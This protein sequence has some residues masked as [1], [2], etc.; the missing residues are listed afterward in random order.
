MEYILGFVLKYLL[1]ALKDWGVGLFK[2]KNKFDSIDKTVDAKRDA[3]IK[4]L[5]EAPKGE[6]MDDATR[7]ALY[8][9]YFNLSNK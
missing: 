9:A 4:I 7:K 6:L 2:K 1:N 5:Q 8:E 3:V